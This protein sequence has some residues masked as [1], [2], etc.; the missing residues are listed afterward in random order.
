MFVPEIMHLVKGELLLCQDLE[1]AR[2]SSAYALLGHSCVWCL[3]LWRLCL[4][5]WA[6]TVKEEQHHPSVLRRNH[7]M[8]PF[9][10][11]C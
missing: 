2:G 6:N 1:F 3:Q 8:H 10:I 9:Y 11:Q 4:C 5:L 7:C